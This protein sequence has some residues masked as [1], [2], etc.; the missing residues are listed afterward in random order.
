MPINDTAKG[1]DAEASAP[2]L[3]VQN[4]ELLLRAVPP[5]FPRATKSGKQLFR[6]GVRDTVTVIRNLNGL[7]SA[8]LIVVKHHVNAVCIGIDRVPYQLGNSKDRLAY[9][10]NPLKVIVSN[11]NLKRFGAHGASLDI[12]LW[13]TLNRRA[14]SAWVAVARAF[15][16]SYS[17]AASQAP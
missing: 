8:E 9:L 6:L 14:K 13:L 12:V 11:L 3:A 10:S 7:D 17:D 15:G 4:A 2:F 1:E 16:A 5:L